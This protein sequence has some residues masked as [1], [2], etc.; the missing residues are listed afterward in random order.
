MCKHRCEGGE[1]VRYVDICGKSFQVDESAM[2][3]PEMGVTG[4]CRDLL[5]GLRDQGGLYSGV[6]WEPSDGGRVLRAQGDVI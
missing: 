3:G 6:R 1:G 4:G 5:R 2:L